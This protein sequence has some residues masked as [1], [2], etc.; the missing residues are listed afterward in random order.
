MIFLD[1]RYVDGT[2]FKAWDSRQNKQE[3]HLTVF[4]TWPQYE[5]NYFLYEWVETDRLDA[6]ASKFLGNSELWWQILDI[7]PEVIDPLEIQPGTQL[8][9]PNA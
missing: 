8:R 6:I 1:S 5:T 7:N 2:L 4:R 3:Y 9:I